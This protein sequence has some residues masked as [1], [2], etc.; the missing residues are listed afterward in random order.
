MR[1]NTEI[2]V[3]KILLEV[4]EKNKIFSIQIRTTGSRD[5]KNKS[6]NISQSN[7]AQLPPDR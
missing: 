5:R 6:K 2:T 3:L 4:T 1:T 7:H